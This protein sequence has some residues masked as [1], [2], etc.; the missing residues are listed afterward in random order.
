MTR[1]EVVQNAIAHRET[2]R[3]PYFINFTRAALPV[4]EQVYPQED[5]SLAI[6]NFVHWVRPPWWTWHEV[7]ETYRS[8]E[9]PDALP[10]TRGTGGYDS[11]Q[12]EL[13]RLRKDTDCYLLVMIYGSHFEKA[14][15]ARGI[16]YFLADLGGN[17]GFAKRMLGKIIDSNMVML[18]NLLTFEGI[19]GVLLGSDWGSQRG[20]LMSPDCWHELIAGGERK[21]YDLIK[22]EGKDVWIHSCGDI[23]AILPDL[24]AM[25]VD[26]LNPVQ[27]ECMDIY[28]LKDQFGDDITFWGGISTQQVLPYGS[29]EE[30]KAEVDTV[31]RGLSRGGGYITSPAQEI[32]DDVPLENMIALLDAVK[33]HG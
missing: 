20:L 27:P 7:P 9:V 17:V 22:S 25:G 26:V 15:A 14:N 30:V 6:G 28:A 12:R 11:F 4:I 1:R 29:P 3:I 23:S 5:L 19:D 16:E 2:D 32:Q 31:V 10:R 18:E 33:A 21:E 8:Y 24:V 13:D